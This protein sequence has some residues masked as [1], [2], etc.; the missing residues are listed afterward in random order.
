[1]TGNKEQDS[2]R[3]PW[4][5]TQASEAGMPL[6]GWV[7]ENWENNLRLGARGACLSNQP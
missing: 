5:Q 1:M 6:T 4:E 2:S 7:Q 3:G